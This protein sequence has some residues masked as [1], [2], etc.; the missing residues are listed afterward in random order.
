M[1]W[2]SD[3]SLF[4]KIMT[5]H[6]TIYSKE[7]EEKVQSISTRNT[8]DYKDTDILTG[9]LIQYCAQ[10]SKYYTATYKYV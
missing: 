6:H 1:T 10:V 4:N 9:L 7:L 8:C 2:S 5:N 3:M